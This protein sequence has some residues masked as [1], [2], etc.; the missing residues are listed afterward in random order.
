[1]VKLTE[2]KTKRRKIAA[3]EG[4]ICQIFTSDVRGGGTNAN[5]FVQVDFGKKS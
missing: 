1:M 5:V 4:W 3:S 2:N